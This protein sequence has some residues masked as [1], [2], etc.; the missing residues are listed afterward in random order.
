MSLAAAGRAS[1]E[2]N[3]RKREEGRSRQVRWEFHG[4][5]WIGWLTPSGGFWG[6][7][8][9]DRPNAPLGM[10]MDFDSLLST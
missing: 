6:V 9:Y 7:F 4:D 10:M 2:K 1:F 3:I 5:W 8:F